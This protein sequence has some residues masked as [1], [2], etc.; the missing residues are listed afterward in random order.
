MQS[1]YSFGGVPFEPK[2]DW[3][4][5]VP[6]FMQET[7]V[8]PRNVPGSGTVLTFGGLGPPELRVTISVTGEDWTAFQS[9]LGRRGVLVY[10]DESWTALL[11]ELDWRRQDPLTGGEGEAHFVA[12]T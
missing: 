8:R 10:G 12:E 5:R 6:G 7:R 9:R 1:R 3:R 11:T 2:P 4:G